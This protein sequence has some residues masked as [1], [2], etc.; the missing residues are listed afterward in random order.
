MSKTPPRPD[1]Q[2]QPSDDPVGNDDY[3][4]T[5]RE[6]VENHGADALSLAIGYQLEARTLRDE[7]AVWFWGRVCGAIVVIRAAQAVDLVATSPGQPTA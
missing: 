2:L 3:R 6:M 7:Q 1:A 5:G 4:R